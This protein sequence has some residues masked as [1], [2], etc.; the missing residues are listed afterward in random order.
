M[1]FAHIV[2]CGLAAITIPTVAL[3]KDSPVR[4]QP[5]TETQATTETPASSTLFPGALD[6]PVADGSNVPSDCA[7]PETLTGDNVD[8]ACVISDDTVPEDEVGIEYIS[9]LGSNGFRHS[10]DIIG[11][12]V[13]TRE[14]ESGCEQ[15]LRIYPHGDEGEP[16]GIWFAFD[17][18][19][20]AA[21]TNHTP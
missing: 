3:A 15:T 1:K 10:A 18:N 19:Q 8:L 5:V 20:C 13:A 16:T 11:G 12:F 4:A 9:W 21:A 17:R 7:F 14:T 2:L 6:I